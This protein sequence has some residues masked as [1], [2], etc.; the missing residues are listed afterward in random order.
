MKE[1][2]VFFE[3]LNCLYK[4]QYRFRSG[5][6]RNQALFEMIE[7]IRKALDLHKFACSI[8]LGLQKAFDTV[9]HEIILEKLEHYRT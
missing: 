2:I 1:L 8:F 7:N 9:N 4:Y 3:K 6:S 5:H